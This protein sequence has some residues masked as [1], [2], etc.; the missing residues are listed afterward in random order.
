MIPT[1]ADETGQHLQC[2]APVT[3][4][5]FHAESDVMF[6]RKLFFDVSSDIESVVEWSPDLHAML[7]YE[8]SAFL[9][10]FKTARTHSH[11]YDT[12]KPHTFGEFNQ[13]VVGVD[14]ADKYLLLL[15]L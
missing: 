3:T 14:K 13:M 6:K 2:D 8:I 10:I 11:R 9:S 1:D 7:H 12:K 5:R 15:Q 4:K